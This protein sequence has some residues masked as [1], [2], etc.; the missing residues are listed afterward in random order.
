MRLKDKAEKKREVFKCRECKKNWSK[1]YCSICGTLVCDKC[2]KYVGYARVCLE[3]FKSILGKEKDITKLKQYLR[4]H[5]KASKR[6]FQLVHRLAKKDMNEAPEVY[7]RIGFDDVDSPYGYCTTYLGAIISKK[8]EESVTFLD[9]PHLIRFNPNIPLKTRG[10]AGIAFYLKVKEKKLEDVKELVLNTIQNSAQSAFPTTESAVVFFSS[11]K[12]KIPLNLVNIYNKA[13]KDILRYEEVTEITKDLSLG[14]LEIFSNT[15]EP[16][17]AIGALASIGA[18]LRDYTF[19]LLAYRSPSL[20]KSKR[21]V[22]KEKLMYFDKMFK[23]VTFANL[24]GGKVLITPHGPDPVLFGLRGDFPLPLLKGLNLLDHEPMERWTLYKTN[25]ATNAHIVEIKRL[26]EG[27]VYQTIKIPLWVRAVPKREGG[28]V[29]LPLSDGENQC[30]AILYPPTGRLRKIGSQFGIGDK[31][32]VTGAVVEKRGKEIELNV[33]AL[34]PLGILPKSQ[35]RNPF[36][37][38]CGERM[39][40]KGQ[41]EYRCPSCGYRLRKKRKLHLFGQEKDIKVKK[42]YLPP[43]DAQRHL[44]LPKDRRKFSI[45]KRRGDLQTS[46]VKPFTGREKVPVSKLKINKFN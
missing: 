10:N 19:E 27:K 1:G 36:C 5:E 35:Q 7:L 29:I 15:A 40:S 18:V 3:C 32:E 39:K 23:D 43:P 4:K 11:I 31:I 16:Q 2:S 25:Q 33:E 12:E 22:S 44:T 26:S 37:P 34:R 28:N 46:F 6:E 38:K 20:Q 14:I 30:K 13:V 21:K 41:E 24:D 9:Y 8:L 17:G 45:L 42:N